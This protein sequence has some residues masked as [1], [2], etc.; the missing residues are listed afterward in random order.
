HAIVGSLALAQKENRLATFEDVF[1][2]LLPSR[3]DVRE[4]AVNACQSYADLDHTTEF[5]AR[6]LP[7]ELENNRANTHQRLD[8]PRNKLEA[9]LASPSLRRFYNHPVDITL[10]EI[11]LNRDVL[12][13]DANMA[14]LGEGNSQVVM[15]LFFQQLHALMQELIHLPPSERPRVPVDWE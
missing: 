4:A 10:R 11:V 1:S 13:I 6:V 9:I 7:E 12:L 8:P 5:F 14:A 3:E 15:H 2:L